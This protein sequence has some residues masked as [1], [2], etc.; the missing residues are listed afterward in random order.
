MSQTI[1]IAFR[2]SE[3]EV[4]AIQPGG[5]E[6]TPDQFSPERIGIS[7]PDHVGVDIQAP[8]EWM[9]LVKVVLEADDRTM[10][11]RQVLE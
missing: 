10:V 11:G 4:S 8:I 5:S 1:P 2:T 3:E 7:T 9:K 6:R